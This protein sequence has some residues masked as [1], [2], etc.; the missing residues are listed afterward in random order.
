MA[1]LVRLLLA[2]L[3]I[4]A[5]VVFAGPAAASESACESIAA[6]T[7]PGARVLSV[8]GVERHDFVVPPDPFNPEPITDIPAFCEAVVTLTHPGADDVVT[9]EAWLPL[10]TWNGRFQGIGGGG[11]SAGFFDPSLAPPVKS[12]YSAASTDAG[13]DSG[14]TAAFDPSGWALRADGT[15][16]KQLLTNFAS[17]SLHDLA[18][19]GKALTASFYG[20]PAAYTYWNGCS[21]GGRQ[22]MMSA[23]R[24][25][26]DYDGIL[27]AAPAI[28]WTKFVMA[29]QWPQVV[30]AQEGN[31]PS[32]CELQAFADAAVAACDRVDKVADGVIGDPRRCRYDPYRLVGKQILCDGQQ[33]TITRAD[34]AVVAK[35]WAGPGVWSGLPKGTPFW[36]VAGQTPFPMAENWIKYFVKRDPTFD[37]STI[38]YR[39]WYRL[40]AR[41]D[42]EFGETIGTDDPDLS[43][44]RAAGGKMVTWHGEADEFIFPA[45]TLDYRARVSRATHGQVDDFFRV[46]MAPGVGHCA[47]GAGPV[48]TDPLAAV[49]AWVEQGKAPETLPAATAT[50]TRDLCRYPLVSR[51]V[52]GDPDV[53]ASFRCARSY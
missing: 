26:T 38:T 47:G 9:I 18:V 49:V 32:D 23:Q 46:F 52:G 41:S 17:R 27:A 24:Y 30:M 40:N 29:E 8:S 39:D 6:P 7:V 31:R 19:A 51:Y 21:T 14:T 10:D 13:V 33:V 20:R 15:V 53:A 34:A 12:G 28:N 11:F 36:G 4:A 1:R 16:N 42:S 50:S 2:V 45:G 3:P 22:G 48:P 35:I 44:F 5:P 37:T 25:P 43:A